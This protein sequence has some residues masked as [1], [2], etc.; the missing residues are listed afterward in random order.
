M[1][2]C[3]GTHQPAVAAAGREG[4]GP[5][6]CWTS[7]K[8]FNPLVSCQLLAGGWWLPPQPPPP[9]LAQSWSQGT[10]SSH[11]PWN[12]PFQTPPG[13][14]HP[15]TP[16]WLIPKELPREALPGQETSGPCR[17]R[18][19]SWHLLSKQHPGDVSVNKAGSAALWLGRL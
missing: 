19:E 17:F 9:C 13:N 7:P 4:T 16:T 6:Q 18:E 14:W 10:P 8:S 3:L 2:S 12:H 15:N 11:Q 5:P 1:G